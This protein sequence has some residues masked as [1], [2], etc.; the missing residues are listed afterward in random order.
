MSCRTG[1]TRVVE[2]ARLATPVER[3]F[4]VGAA[5]R[6]TLQ[7]AERFPEVRDRR[8]S[9]IVESDAATPLALVVEHSTYWNAGGVFWSAGSSA[10]ATRLR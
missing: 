1:P 10:T 9:A 7:M 2:K 4:P 3:T 5:S 8:F 6:L